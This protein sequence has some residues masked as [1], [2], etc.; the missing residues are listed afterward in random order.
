MVPEH[1]RS[2]RAAI[3]VAMPFQS[4]N[5]RRYLWAKQPSVAKRWAAEYGT[6]KNLPKHKK[7]ARKVR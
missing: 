7:K 5:Q 1:G 6:P 2:T 4:E 3:L